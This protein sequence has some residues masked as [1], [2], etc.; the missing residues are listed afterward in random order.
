ENNLGGPAAEQGC[1]LA[2]R[3][4]DGGF[5]R[6]RRPMSTRWVTESVIEKRPHHGGNRR[7]HGSARV[8]VK[9]DARGA[10]PNLPETQLLM[11]RTTS[12]KEYVVGF[13]G[14]TAN[15]SMIAA[16]GDSR[17]GPLRSIA[18]SPGAGRRPV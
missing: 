2:S 12:E 14:G 5:C 16:I 7:G 10:H 18:P 4:L 13:C 17:G 8:V 6:R 1:G 3:I 11:L 15:S 9:I